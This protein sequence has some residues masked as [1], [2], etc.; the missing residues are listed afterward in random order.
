MNTRANQEE[1]DR[2]WKVRI[3]PYSANVA[4]CLQK[5]YPF[6]VEKLMTI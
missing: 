5:D 6:G 1:R 4:G 3:F 2:T